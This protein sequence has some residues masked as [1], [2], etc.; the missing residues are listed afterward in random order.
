MQQLNWQMQRPLP[1]LAAFFLLFESFGICQM[2]SGSATKIPGRKERWFVLCVV[3]SGLV[4]GL[5]LS[6]QV[7][8]P[9][10]FCCGLSKALQCQDSCACPAQSKERAYG[11]CCHIQLKWAEL[12]WSG[13]AMTSEYLSEQLCVTKLLI[14]LVEQPSRIFSQS[15]PLWY[16][17][18]A[19]E[20]PRAK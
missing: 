6:C 7:L 4:L 5:G 15:S 19:K 14:L 20:T 17:A 12:F 13:W 1:S 11:Q 2:P 9:S 16:S 18:L 3:T 8:S 10:S